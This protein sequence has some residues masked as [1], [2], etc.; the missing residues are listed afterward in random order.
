[1]ADKEK[2]S[3]EKVRQQQ[4]RFAA[5]LRH[6]EKNPAPE[7]IEDRRLKVYREL[8]FNSMV[9]LLSSTYPVLSKILGDDR[10]RV[11]VRD[12]YHRHQSHTPLFPEVPE[13]FLAYL[14]DEF[15]NDGSWPGFMLELAHYEWVELALSISEKEISDENLDTQG[16]ILT[17]IPVLSPVAWPLAYEWPV[18]QIGPGFEPEAPGE[19]ATFLVVYRQPDDTIGFTEINAMTARLLELIGENESQSGEQLLRQV[20]A[21]IGHPDPDKIV[22]GG[23]DLLENLRSRS[24]VPGTRIENRGE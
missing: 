15:E 22:A 20:A 24:I 17:G 19:N 1:M 23:S 3:A 4:Y 14:Q 6:P 8:F 16:N 7:G 10:W 21:E 5:H 12:F 2:S 13:E 9:S 18:H 11:L